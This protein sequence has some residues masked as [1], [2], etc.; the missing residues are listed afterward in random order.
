MQDHT[1][2]VGEELIIA[3]HIRLTI[4]AVEEGKVVLGLT[5]EPTA[6]RG[7]LA[8]PWRDW[9]TAVPVPISNDN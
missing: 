6:V 1:L 3:D 9:L 5:A 7:P 2:R 8:H 4:L